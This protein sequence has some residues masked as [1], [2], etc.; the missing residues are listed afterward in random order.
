MQRCRKRFFKK[1]NKTHLN[2]L[3]W[4]NIIGNGR[5]GNGEKRFLMNDRKK[6]YLRRVRIILEY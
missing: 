5:E 1:K 3:Q 2:M 6:K 4:K